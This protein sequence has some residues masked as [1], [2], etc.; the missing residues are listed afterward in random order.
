ME[1]WNITEAQEMGVGV[2][3][4]GG[5]R[6]GGGW[7]VVVV[8]MLRKKYTLQNTYSVVVIS[9]C[10]GKLSSY[11]LILLPNVLLSH[12]IDI[13]VIIKVWDCIMQIVAYNFSYMIQTQNLENNVKQGW[14]ELP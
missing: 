12:Q 13:F 14:L 10:S 7:V 4:G 6:G 9:V 8:L 5:G 3:G 2:G 11:I 1:G